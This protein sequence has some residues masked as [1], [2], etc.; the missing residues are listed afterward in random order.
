MYKAR[1]LLAVFVPVGNCHYR[2]GSLPPG[3]SDLTLQLSHIAFR[4]W[5]CSIGM[6]FR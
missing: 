4:Q 6:A 2:A 3:D 5:G 1:N